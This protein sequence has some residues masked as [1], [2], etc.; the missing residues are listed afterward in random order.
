MVES[1]AAIAATISAGT[2]VTTGV[3]AR[4]DQKKSLAKQQQQQIQA[5]S[6]AIND[7]TLADQKERSLRQREPDVNALLASA[8][9]PRAP[10]SILSGAAGID[11][12]KL[13]LG[14]LKPLGE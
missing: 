12:T 13:N 9:T 6:A 3:V 14:K 1:L 10:S 5:Q 4:R 11:P 2:A 7:K 8:Q